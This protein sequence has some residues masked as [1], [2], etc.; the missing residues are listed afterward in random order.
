ML[1]AY[2]M[3]KLEKFTL[4]N[5]DR[6]RIKVFEPFEDVSKPILCI[7]VMMNSYGFVY[8]RSIKQVMKGSRVETIKNERKEYKKLLEQG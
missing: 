5:K 2:L 1:I 6:S 3:E 7:N 4:I 8:K